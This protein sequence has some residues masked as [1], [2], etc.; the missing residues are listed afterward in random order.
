MITP[1]ETFQKSPYAK[2]WL[3]LCD[4]K[5]FEAAS[6]AA[7]L[8][9]TLR[10]RNSPDLATSAA[11]QKKLEGALLFLDVLTSLTLPPPNQPGPSSSEN[12]DHR[13]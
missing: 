9:I 1:R 6:S 8:E 5:Q 12:L 4:S 10:F 13:I 3:D 7:L 11:C 2:G